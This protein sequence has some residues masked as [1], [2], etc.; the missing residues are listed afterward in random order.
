MLLNWQRLARSSAASVASRD[1]ASSKP[2]IRTHLITRSKQQD[3][4]RH[5]ITRLDG[6]LTTHLGVT[7]TLS[8][9][10]FPQV[11]SSNAPHGLPE[12]QPITAVD[13]HNNKD[14][15]GITRVAHRKGDDRGDEQR[16]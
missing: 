5:E 10:S 3:V 2:C 7:R 4:S 1:A 14:D 15:H 6:G 9:D 12:W 8:E 13:E 11:R 16:M